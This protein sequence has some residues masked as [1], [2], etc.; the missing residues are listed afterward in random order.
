MA[1][2]SHAVAPAAS[3]VRPDLWSRALSSPR[4]KKRDAERERERENNYLP[5]G[6]EKKKKRSDSENEK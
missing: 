1:D 6:D 2:S 4:R 5:A 3:E